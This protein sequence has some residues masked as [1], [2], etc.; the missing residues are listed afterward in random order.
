MRVKVGING[1]GRM[2]RLALRI[3]WAKNGYDVIH[4]NELGGS[5]EQAAHLL[6]FDTIHGRWGRDISFGSDRLKIDG[7]GVGYSMERAPSDIKWDKLGVDIVLECSGEFK[8]I[9]ELQPHFRNGASKVIVSAPIK[10]PKTLNVVMGVNDH[11]YCNEKHNLISGASCTTNCLAPIIK[12]MLENFKIKHGVITSIHDVTNT[13]KM[14]DGFHPDLRRARSGLNALIPTST[15]SAT[16]ITQIYPELTGKLDGLAVRV[17]ILN[18]SLT[19]CVFE[20]DQAT[21]P[22]K[23]NTYFQEASEGSLKNILGFERRPLVSTDYVNDP[24]SAIIDGPSTMVVDGTQVKI[25]AWYDNEWGYMTRF[26][27]LTEKISNEL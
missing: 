22:K 15:G 26:M 9:K 25:L 27:E 23:L 5:A 20:V 11:L 16:A 3:G 17:P 18:S 13:Q 24:R 19:D 4:V 6:E 1:F 21:T 10:D 2:G 7:I 14:V 12:V 8:T